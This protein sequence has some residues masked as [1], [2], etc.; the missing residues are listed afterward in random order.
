MWH[1]PQHTTH[2]V[3]SVFDDCEHGS[4]MQ[5]S[6]I[7]SNLTDVAMEEGHLP[8][9]F[10]IGADNA[11]KETKNQVCFWFAVWLLCVLQDTNLWVVSFSF[12]LVGHTHDALDRF[13][14]RLVAAIAGRDFFTV[15]QL[16][17]TAQQKLELLQPQGT[18]SGPDMGV[19]RF[20]KPSRC[21]GCQRSRPSPRHQVL[22]FQWDLGAVETVDDR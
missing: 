14:S 22:P 10:H 15:D 18:P 7:L 6:A 16:F 20:T 11:Y 19:E 4:E 12:L 2:L 21:K 8:D 1:G 9:E 17:A 13:F 5:C 3:R